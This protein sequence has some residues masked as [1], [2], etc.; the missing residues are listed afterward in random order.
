MKEMLAV[1]ALVVVILTFLEGKLPEGA[2][3][4][5]TVTVLRVLSM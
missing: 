4:C 1:T 3:P 2:T 5:F